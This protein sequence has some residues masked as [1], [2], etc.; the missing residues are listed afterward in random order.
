VYEL[1]LYLFPIEYAIITVQI[2]KTYTTKK[3]DKIVHFHPTY[4]RIPLH[5]ALSLLLLYIVLIFFDGVVIFCYSDRTVPK[6]F[7]PW[8]FFLLA[9]AFSVSDIQ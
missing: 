8:F 6:K 5:A 1:I 7:K 3:A 9:V 4:L 2:R